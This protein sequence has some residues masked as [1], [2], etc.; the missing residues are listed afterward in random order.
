MF[1][2]LDRWDPSRPIKPWLLTIVANRCRT[3][4][5]RRSK[6]LSQN[7]L[8]IDLEGER[9]EHSKHEQQKV[10]IAEELD[11]AL[12]ELREEY[13]MC[14]VLLYQQELSYEEIEEILDRPQ[15]TVK[16]WLHPARAQLAEC[17]RERGVICEAS[18]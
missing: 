13:R 7:E 10:D 16:M 3:A 5:E 9:C 17:L 15:G 12:G 11:V 14:F 8:E 2:D 1:R 18:S 4:L 6:L